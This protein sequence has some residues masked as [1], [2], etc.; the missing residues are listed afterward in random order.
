M[1]GHSSIF[2]II[3]MTLISVFLT[4]GATYL[5]IRHRRKLLFLSAVTVALISLY[6]VFTWHPALDWL[7][8]AATWRVAYTL[9]LGGFLAFL[10]LMRKKAKPFT[11]KGW[12]W[13]MFVAGL[14]AFLAFALGGFVRE[15]SKSPY[16]VYK[17][18]Q[19]PEVTDFEADRFLVYDKCVD[20]HHKTPKDLF[21]YTTINWKDQVEI[22]R[23]RPGVQITD[24]EASRIVRFLQEHNE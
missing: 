14:A 15:H 17:E 20:C 12:P 6:F 21:R 4:I 3:K 7:G 8:S 10:W 11:D 22:E 18:I 2:F 5:F 16:T 19:K 9:I 13:L 24:E 1:G 23:N